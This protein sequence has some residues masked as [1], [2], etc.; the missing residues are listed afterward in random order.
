MTPEEMDGQ[1]WK[2]KIIF[3]TWT[4]VVKSIRKDFY[5]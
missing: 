5:S 3:K 4:Q 2:K 1:F